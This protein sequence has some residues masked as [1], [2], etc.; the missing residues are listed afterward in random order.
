MGNGIN[1]LGK[2]IVIPVI[3]L[4]LFAGWFLWITYEHSKANAIKS[5]VISALSVAV[6]LQQYEG[7]RILLK[8]QNSLPF[9]TT[10]FNDTEQ[11]I[12]VLQDMLYRLNLD[13]TVPPIKV[14]KFKMFQTSSID[15]H[16]TTK[17]TEVFGIKK[18]II[19]H[20]TAKLKAFKNKT[21]PEQFD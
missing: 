3:V 13:Q 5:K 1:R 12:K 2:K 16:I 17:Y 21:G 7:E 8:Q 18:S 14:S 19:V 10:N 6:E 4:I 11:Q 20:T 9:Y 15:I